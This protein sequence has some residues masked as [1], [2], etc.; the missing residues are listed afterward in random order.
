MEREGALL[1]LA[2]YYLFQDDCTDLEEIWELFVFTFELRDD[3]EVFMS[4]VRDNRNIR[5]SAV[6]NPN[7]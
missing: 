2:T 7:L 1:A 3:M 5:V 4:E 6:T